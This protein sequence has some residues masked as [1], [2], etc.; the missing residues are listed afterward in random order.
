LHWQENFAI[1]YDL[2]FELR[3]GVEDLHFRLHLVDG[4]ISTLLQLL[5]TF[6]DASLAYPTGAASEGVSS[7]ASDDDNLRKQ[8]VAEVIA[9]PVQ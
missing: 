7:S 9:E 3:Q 4:R 1:L 6:Q 5:S 8:G 2:V